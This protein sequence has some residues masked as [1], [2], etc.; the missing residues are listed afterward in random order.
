[1]HMKIQ[2]YADVL[3][4]INF[5]MNLVILHICEK[6]LACGAKKWRICLAAAGGGVYSVCIFFPQA[7]VLYTII[8]KLAVSAAIVLISFPTKSPK[9]FL[10]R[11]GMFYLVSFALGG[12]CMA[13]M[14]FTDIGGKTGA[15]VKNGAFYM[16][17]PLRT[18]AFSALAA[19]VLIRAVSF[20][21][22]RI[23]SRKIYEVTIRMGENVVKTRGL[24]DTG[25][26]LSEPVSG[27][28][29]PVAEW[30]VVSSLLPAGCTKDN[31]IRYVPP[32]RIKL[33]PYKSVGNENG[34]MWAVR[35]DEM[36]LGDRIVEKPLVGI[37]EGMLSE[38]YG[39]LLHKGFF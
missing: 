9:A 20:M 13:V 11:L 4:L 6:L 1:M 32:E 35:A 18:V 8:L 39:I 12:A 17:L 38:D 30:R 36:S 26:S 7:A 19:Y 14:Y 16:Q 3:F 25:N 24:L 31:F 27:R 21:M 28:P 33:I 22:K 37:Y 10:L 34:V 5:C 2:V 15:I 29:V 23:R